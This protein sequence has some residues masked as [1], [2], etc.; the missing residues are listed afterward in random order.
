VRIKPLNGRLERRR[1]RLPVSRFDKAFGIARKVK[2]FLNPEV[3]I[4]RGAVSDVEQHE[5]RVESPEQKR[6]PMSEY[7]KKIKKRD[8]PPERIETAYLRQLPDFVIIGT[9]RG[10]TTSLYRYLTEHPDVGSALRKEVHFFD[11]YYEKG[12]DWYLANFPMRGEVP[13]VGEASPSYLFHPEVPQRARAAVSH[14]K[15]IVL[16]RNP[17]DRA[18]S[19]YQLVVRRGIE[20]LSFE[21]AID[22]EPERLN[23]SDDPASLTWRYYSYIKRG[24][25]VDQLKRW[26]G[27]FPREQFLIIKSEDFYNN[28]ERVLHQTLAY[29]G[30]RPWSPVRFKA[31]HLA[32]YSDIDPVTR[33]HL[34]EYF[35]PYNQQLYAFLGRDLGWE[36]EWQ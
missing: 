28:P 9:Q 18:Y 29:L 30:L 11:R 36:H 7:S 2:A 5:N 8:P 16:L 17:V 12:M 34:G 3:G 32:E 4:T 10:G 1:R 6:R 13:V 19:H 21:D 20:T 31:Y 23:S 25:Y 24:L 26:M 15:F 33:K 35:A 22:K 14:A 27:V